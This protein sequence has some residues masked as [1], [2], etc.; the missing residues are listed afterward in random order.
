MIRSK[1]S[2]AIIGCLGVSSKNTITIGGLISNPVIVK[3]HDFV[4]SPV[5]P[6]FLT[7]SRLSA[8]TYFNN[9][10]VLSDAAADT[11][12]FD[13]AFNGTVWVNQ[14]L[15]IEKQSTN[16]AY[17]NSID[18]AGGGARTQ[19][20]ASQVDISNT[21]NAIKATSVIGQGDNFFAYGGTQNFSSV[22]TRTY[23]V[24]V[25]TQSIT[26]Y[27]YLRRIQPGSDSANRYSN[28]N[29]VLVEE[30]AIF[31]T[32]K[33][34][35]Q[36]WIR[37]SYPF[38]INASGMYARLNVSSQD[39]Y[40]ASSTLQASV[41]TCSAQLE[42]GDYPTSFIRT[43]TSAV[44]RSQDYL[45]YNANNYTGS[46]KLIYKRQDTEIIESTWLDLTNATNPIISSSLSVGAWLQNIKVYNRILT[47]QEKSNV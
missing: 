45:R 4:A 21:S 42:I 26:H 27:F 13:C 10:G 19:I 2:T 11:A 9:Q 18:S 33:K 36:N 28:L 17:N 31:Q 32:T 15:L 5:L 29:N 6:S 20:T 25:K 37:L 23:S 14:G 7:L 44:T 38:Q 22:P 12:R 46:I 47:A 41:I 43:T 39:S 34:Q 24:Y 16:Y 3:Q 30:I 40:T 8:A 35:C 1:G